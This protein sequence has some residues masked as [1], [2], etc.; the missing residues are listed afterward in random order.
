LVSRHGCV[1][2]VVIATEFA[3]YNRGINNVESL[4]FKQ[5]RS[6]PIAKENGSFMVKKWTH[7][8]FK[9]YGVQPKPFSPTNRIKQNYL[10]DITTQNAK[11]ISDEIT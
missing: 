2:I 3:K 1:V 8:G 7:T 11:K 4:T 5:K 10:F 9:I 6:E